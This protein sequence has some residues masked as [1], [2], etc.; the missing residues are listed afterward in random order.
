[1][2]GKMV[3]IIKSMYKLQKVSLKHQDKISQTFPKNVALKQ[4]DVLKTIALKIYMNYLLVQLLED[5]RFSN[6]IN[7]TPYLHDS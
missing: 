5:S 4:S 1:M 7:D 3:Y 2:L 6:T